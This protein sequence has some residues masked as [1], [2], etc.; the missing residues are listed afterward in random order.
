MSATR[1][2]RHRLWWY[3]VGI[4]GLRRHDVMVSSFPK[5]GNTWVRFFLANLLSLREWDGQKVDF[6]ILD[7]RMIELG[8]SNLIAAPTPTTL[9]RFIKTHLPYSAVFRD[10]RAILIVR[11]P[12]D[13]MASFYSYE[14]N[15]THPRVSGT[16]SEFLQHPRFGLPGW[17]KHTSSWLNRASVVIRYEDM[18]SDPESCFRTLL[19]DLGIDARPE[20]VAEAT[21]RASQKQVQAI[22]EAHGISNPERFREGFQ[23]TQQG[24]VG[25][26]ES[27]FNDA[28]LAHLDDLLEQ[29]GID[30]YRSSQI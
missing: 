8:K 12:R 29:S 7:S 17:V 15:Q 24:G 9:P 20:E 18:R 19:D 10:R 5:S 30:M 3:T 23:F 26:G 2:W 27:L 21:R 11:D 14:G 28:E 13:V 25:R 4:A 16:F 22:E 6:D 1:T